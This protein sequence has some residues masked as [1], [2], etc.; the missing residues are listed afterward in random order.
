MTNTNGLSVLLR[1][2]GDLSNSSIS[3]G[4]AAPL[5]DS[6]LVVDDIDVD[7]LANWHHSDGG[8]HGILVLV[9]EDGVVQSVHT[10]LVTS[11][12]VGVQE[13]SLSRLA[14]DDTYTAVVRAGES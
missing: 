4:V 14:C 8:V 2:C 11:K 3:I 6:C 1:S 5:E 10:L 9:D 13:I 7:V 12:V